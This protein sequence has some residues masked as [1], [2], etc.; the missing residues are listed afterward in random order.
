MVAVLPVGAGVR[1]RIGYFATITFRKTTTCF[2]LRAGPPVGWL[3]EALYATD[4]GTHW[5]RQRR[6]V[7]RVRRAAA[8]AA[9]RR[10]GTGAGRYV[11]GGRR[12]SR[13]RP[14]PDDWQ[15]AVEWCGERWKTVRESCA[16][17]H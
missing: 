1:L 12:L 11:G 14:T 13:A 5:K 6:R 4:G 2:V 16:C 8:R 3:Q 9:A 15:T 10:D 7:R 17:T